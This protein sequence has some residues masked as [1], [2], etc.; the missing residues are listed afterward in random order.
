MA[1]GRTRRPGPDGP[2]AL[3]LETR[4]ETA[5]SICRLIEG[6]QAPWQKPWRAG[7][8][9][10]PFNPV[11]GTGY[12]GYNRLVLSLH[13]YRDPRW[14]SFL[15]A[16][17]KGWRVRAGS[18]A[19]HIEFWQWSSSRRV[20]DRDGRPVVDGQGSPV[21]I[22]VDLA[23]PWF[24]RFLVFNATQ[25]EMP[26]GG[27]IPGPEPP[28]VP[29]AP[30]AAADELIRASGARIVHDRADSCFYDARADAIHMPEKGRF[31]TSGEFYSSVLHELAHW[32][33]HPSRMDRGKAGEGA[34]YAREELRAEIASWM[35]CQ[36]LG[37]DYSPGNHAAYCRHWIRGL[38]G[39]PSE[40]VRACAEAERIKDFLLAPVQGPVQGPR[41]RPGPGPDE[42]AGVPPAAGR[43]PAGTPPAPAGIDRLAAGAG[44]GL[45]GPGGDSRAGAPP[46]RRPARRPD[47]DYFELAQSPEEAM[48]GGPGP[49]PGEAGDMRTMAANKIVAIL[50]R[51]G[52]ALSGARRWGRVRDFCADRHA[53]GRGWDG[54]FGRFLEEAWRVSAHQIR[55]CREIFGAGDVDWDR[56]EVSVNNSLL[57]VIDSARQLGLPGLLYPH[58]ESF[59]PAPLVARAEGEGPL[60]ILSLAGQEFRGF[61]L[62]LEG[63]TPRG[64]AILREGSLE[65]VNVL[66][67]ETNARDFAAALGCHDNPM[68]GKYLREEFRDQYRQRLLVDPP[69]PPS[70]AA[71]AALNRSLLERAMVRFH[72]GVPPGPLFDED[73]PILPVV[74]PPPRPPAAARPVVPYRPPAPGGAPGGAPGVEGPAR[75]GPSPR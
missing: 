15:Q 20:L 36:D 1:W 46:G 39:D 4:R 24:R 37:L 60:G 47:P 50:C 18:R 54:R 11:S 16:Q 7:E 72:G 58:G 17:Q 34:G 59:V 23:R 52:L 13:D 8:V 9:G 3:A 75:R 41:R 53:P 43:R 70:D 51:P 68:L 64:Y 49:A 71:M 42:A 10:L 14:L 67:D 56:R 62:A 25:L 5:Q 32:T 28:A 30:E 27:P 74:A 19:Q 57:L 38:Q 44:A 48:A 22:R 29:W 31:P 2:A 45:A 65:V 40:I 73:D 33:R 21:E 35:L 26:G 63:E 66:R 69:A 12:R 6:H 55:L 61:R